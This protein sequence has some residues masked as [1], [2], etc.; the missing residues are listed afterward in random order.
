MTK[1][2]FSLEC[3]SPDVIVFDVGGRRP[4]TAP[5]SVLWG[6]LQA[7][8]DVRTLDEWAACTSPTEWRRREV[9]LITVGIGL[10]WAVHL[11]DAEGHTFEGATPDEARAKAAAW[12]RE[13]KP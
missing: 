8:A 12:V 6:E 5:E 1:L 11:A 7:L 4:A 13:Q 2:G 10:G 9:R 3:G